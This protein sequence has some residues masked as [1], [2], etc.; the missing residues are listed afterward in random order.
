M[1]R[2]DKNLLSTDRNHENSRTF[3]AK[4]S[5]A[6]G[7]LTKESR[8]IGGLGEC[9][10]QWP[11]CPA[12]CKIRR[13]CK[14]SNYARGILKAGGFGTLSLLIIHTTVFALRS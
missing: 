3:N 14:Q 6:I 12:S 2:P 1:I 10:A 13:T 11:H 7:K 4:V 9:S 5:R 8:D